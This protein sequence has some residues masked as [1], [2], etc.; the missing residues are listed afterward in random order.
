MLDYMH[1]DAR[2]LDKFDPD[3]GFEPRWRKRPD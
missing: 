2:E 3:D 1:A